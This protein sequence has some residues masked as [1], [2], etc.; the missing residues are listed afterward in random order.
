MNLSETTLKSLEVLG[1]NEA[2]EV[3]EKVIKS[4]LNNESLIVQSQTGSG[5]TAAFGIPIV[6]H[7]DWDNRLPQALVLAPTRELALQIQEEIF[8]IGRFK[9][10]IVEAVFGRSSFEAQEKKLRG[11]CH[12]VV[13]TPGRLIDHI[14]RGTI[15]LSEVKTLIIDEADEML[16]MGFIDQI[17][18]VTKAL[19][20]DKTISLFSATMPDKIK[21]LSQQIMKDAKFVKVEAVNAVDDRILQERYFVSQKQK[22]D[23]L[24]EILIL[25]NPNSSIIFCNT[26][27]NVEM[28]ADMLW[29][30]GINVETLH[31]DM[32]QRDRTYV[33]NEFKRA[34]FRYLVATDV[35]ARGLDI[36][37]IAL[38]VNYDLPEN[39]A[40]Y[41]H[42]IG[43]TARIEKMGKAISLVD[44]YETKY[45]TTILEDTQFQ[46]DNMK[47]PSESMLE[48]KKDAFN[49]KI[50]RQP[51]RKQAKGDDFKNQ[52]TKLHINAGKKT[53]MRPVDLVGALCSIDGVEKDDIGVIGIVDVSTFVEILNG[54][55]KLVL[56]T[57]QTMPIKGRV[58]KASLANQHLE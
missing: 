57:L 58:R 2:T 23:A 16:D 46:I 9:R 53:K 5:K 50:L 14:E 36:D 55:G 47:R 11:L 43:R 38:V 49:A 56:D 39:T 41:I 37:D 32:E 52:I 42:R 24:K 35:A 3:Q 4:L 8:N 21:E 44:D 28:V 33:I 7:I 26:K 25:E 19:P 6:E 54:K 15:D 22:M 51:K 1:Y 31:G 45:L 18:A 27:A 30:L 48:S 10:L 34:G 13:A 20:K 12:V 40:S 29:G 17:K